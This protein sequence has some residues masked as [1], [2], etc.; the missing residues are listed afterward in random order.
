M[1]PKNRKNDLIGAILG[2]EMDI[3]MLEEDIDVLNR[4]LDYL[5]AVRHEMDGNLIFLK[6]K[7]ICISLKEY[8]KVLMELGFLETKIK[9]HRQLL[10][11]LNSQMDKKLEALEHYQRLH[12][13]EHE[14]LSRK[15]L[16]F[17]R[18]THEYQEQSQSQDSSR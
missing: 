8:K 2:I 10:T 14:Y 4:D 12:E 17:V 15:I 11:S 1:N 13:I 7:A 6:E 18:K 5:D 9:Q 3:N 16:P